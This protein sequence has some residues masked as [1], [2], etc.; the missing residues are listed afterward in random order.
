MP[1]NDWKTIRSRCDGVVR[2]IET[3]YV[4]TLGANRD[5]NVDK[6]RDY[7]MTHRGW[8]DIGY[9]WVVTYDGE[10]QMGR[11]MRRQGAG[12]RLDNRTSVHVCFTGHG[13]LQQWTSEQH[14]NGITLL[15]LLCE[16][17][18]LNHHDVKGHREFHGV[19][20][21]C[22]G[23]LINMIDV[24]LAVF[25]ALDLSIEE[26]PYPTEDQLA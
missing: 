13:D 10:V 20:K 1:E 6:I 16:E 7:H 9:H 15:A 23:K 17:F 22:P 8:S 11:P 25:D 14:A 18:E 24:R 4:H 2:Q 21:S 19:K 12:V 3:L 5:S 26:P